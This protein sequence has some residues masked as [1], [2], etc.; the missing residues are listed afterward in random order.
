MEPGPRQTAMGGIHHVQPLIFEF[1]ALRRKE[2]AF[3]SS[4][5]CSEKDK[6]TSIYSTSLK[7]ISGT[8]DKVNVRRIWK[9]HSE[10]ESTE[11]LPW[12]ATHEAM[13]P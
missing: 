8:S 4:G 11:W 9:K 7:R 10:I 13:L 6:A 12:A 2:L 1:N 3:L 5:T